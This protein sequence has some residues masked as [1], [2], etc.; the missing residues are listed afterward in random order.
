MSA[1]IPV[2]TIAELDTLDD[3]EIL[4]GYMDGLRGEPE[5]GDNRSKAY[6]HGWRNGFVD[7][8]HREHD[9]AGIALAADC[10]RTGYLQRPQFRLH[11]SP[12]RRERRA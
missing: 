11:H 10:Q 3:A 7:G 6:W 4:E 2:T 1:R 12:A 8:G 9:P 5:P